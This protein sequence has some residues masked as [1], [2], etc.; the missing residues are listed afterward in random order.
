MI[1]ATEAGAIIFPATPGFYHNPERVEDLVDSV[2]GRVLDL[3][4]VETPFLKRWTG[5][6]LAEVVSFKREEE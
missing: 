4:G 2:V 3:L 6:A 1:A 5:P